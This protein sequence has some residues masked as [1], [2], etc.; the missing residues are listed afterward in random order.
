MRGLHTCGAQMSFQCR[1]FFRAFARLCDKER[2]ASVHLVGPAESTAARSRP[3]RFWGVCLINVL[4]PHEPAHG[5]VGSA[6][7]PHRSVL[8]DESG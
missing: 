8:I 5:G 6:P 1:C 2:G 7:P 3:R 4:P